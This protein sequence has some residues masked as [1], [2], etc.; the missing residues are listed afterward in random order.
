MRKPKQKCQCSSFVA[1]VIQN[2][3]T[4]RSQLSP[5]LSI[6]RYV[7]C[8][9]H[10]EIQ[11]VFHL[12]ILLN[13]WF[14]SSVLT[15]SLACS[16]SYWTAS[17]QSHPTFSATLFAVSSAFSQLVCWSGSTSWRISSAF[18]VTDRRKRG[19]SL[20]WKFPEWNRAFISSIL[21][22]SHTYIRQVFAAVTNSFLAVTTA[23][24]SI[25]AQLLKCCPN[26]FS[27]SKFFH[28]PEINCLN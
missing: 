22:V 15:I 13:F 18:W 14:Y 11:Q 27:I 1:G 19:T 16:C 25:I 12:S 20:A 3:P 8:C 10:D 6:H 17:H 9:G 23:R 28:F 7:A 5:G 24:Y 26:C 2:S 21:T 4:K